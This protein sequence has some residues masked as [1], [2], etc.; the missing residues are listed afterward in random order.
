MV[1]TDW[2]GIQEK[3]HVRIIRFE[4]YTK[5]QICFFRPISFSVLNMKH[6]IIYIIRIIYYL[7]LYILYIHVFIYINIY[8][9]MFY[10]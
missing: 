8:Y 10:I 7:Y 9:Y 2:E 5:T 1:F 6:E 4:K 3:T